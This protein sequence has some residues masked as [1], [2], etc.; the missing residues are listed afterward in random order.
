MRFTQTY[1]SLHTS[2]IFKKRGQRE[3]KAERKRGEIEGEK[4]DAMKESR[5]KLCKG[6]KRS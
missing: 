4:K 1:V 5:K 2:I 3:E 6:R